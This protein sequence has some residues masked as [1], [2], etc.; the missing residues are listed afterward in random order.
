MEA[1]ARFTR[2]RLLRGVGTL[3]LVALSAEGLRVYAFTNR[4]TIIPGIAYRSAQLSPDELDAEIRRHGIRTVVNLRGT[5]P[6]TGWY[7]GEARVTHQHNI[8]QEDLCLS[9]KR[10]P[11]PSEV[12]RMI[13]VLD[14]TERPMLIH[15]QRGA[16]RTGLVST[17]VMLLFT[18]ATLDE[19]RRQLWPRY[20]HIR[21][22]RTVVI[23]EFFEF[24]DAWLAG[25]GHTPDLYR[26][27]VANHYRPGPFSA[28][29]SVVGAK[30][31]V[32]RGR[33]FAVTIRV[34]NTSVQAWTFRTGPA[35]G[36]QLRAGLFNEAGAKLHTARAGLFEGRLEPGQSREFTVGFPP[37]A[38]PGRYLVHADML[39]S[40]S[41]DLHDSD[42]VQYGSEPLLFDVSVK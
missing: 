2:R 5:C 28:E 30:P 7:D 13:E 20:G 41:I 32:E 14:R 38:T 25:R 37:L 40:Q 39:D 19:A 4:H 3:A 9:A 1:P 29:L 22:G 17:S 34:K 31:V 21:G 33:G 11:A 26:E 6:D 36:I 27:W 42:F 35:G 24:Y 8:S 12:R 16:D 15:C 18:N 23:D 10:L